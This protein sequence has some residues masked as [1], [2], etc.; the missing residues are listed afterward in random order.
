M[1]SGSWVAELYDP[2]RGT[3]SSTGSMSKSRSAYSAT[4]LPDGRV[5]VT[6]GWDGNSYHSSTEIY[7][8]RTGEW[9]DAAQMEVLRGSHETFPLPDGRVIVV[10]G[11]NW[12][13]TRQAIAS[14]EI[15]DP[16]NNV[17]PQSTPSAERTGSN[18]RDA[19]RRMNCVPSSATPFVSSRMRRAF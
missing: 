14:T 17:W 16:T 7:D 13:T 15:Y 1:T 5:L 12:F 2:Q 10:G 11:N 19:D 9:T 4:L 18:R 8:P 6:G 3:W